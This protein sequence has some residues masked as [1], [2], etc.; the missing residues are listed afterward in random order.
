MLQPTEPLSLESAATQETSFRELAHWAI[1]IVRRQLLVIALIGAL[2]TSLGVFYV[3]I[4]PSTYTAESRIAID[5]RRVQLFPKAT[6]SEGQIDGPAL[7]SETVLAQSEPVVLSVV[8]SLGLAK[9][10]E[11]LKSPGVLGALLG[12]ASHLFSLIKST[13]P[14]SESEATKVA[15]T[16]LSK[17]LL[18]FRV[19]GSYNLSIQYQ[20]ANPERAVQIANAIVEAYI[21]KQLEVKYEPTKRATQ[22]LEG[23]IKELNEKQKLAERLVVDFKKNNNVV[24]AD[25]K[26]MNEQL[27]ADLSSQ[28]SQA[29]Q[30]VSEAK[31]RV[32]RINAVIRDAQMGRVDAGT[33]ADTL[34]KQ[35]GAT[36]SETLNSTVASTLRTRY[37]ELVNREASWSRKYGAK[38]A[39]VVNLR[40]QIHEI[41]GSFLEELKRL[42]DTY[43]NTYEVV[44]SEEQ[45][46]EKRFD[47]AVSRSQPISQ[48]QITL[49]DLESNAKN[50]RT[51][52]DEF[53]QRY[54]DSLQQQSF[55]ISDASITA[56]AALPLEKSGPKTAL[57]LVMAA[58]GGLGFG[59]AVGILRELMDGSFYTK[60]QV[61]SALQTPCIAVVPS[62]KGDNSYNGPTLMGSP[63]PMLSFDRGLD[64]GLNDQRTISRGPD[65]CWAVLNSPFCRFAEGIRSIK[66]AVDL[67]R[68]AVNSKK[69]IGFISSLPHEGKSTIAASLALLMAQASAR[70]ILVDCDLRNPSL[71][72]RLAPNADHGIL[73]VTAGRT[74]LKNA[75]WTDQST[76]L[77]FLPAVTNN[78][79]ICS[80]DILSADATGKLF[81]NLR[82]RYDYVL[83]DLTPLMPI[84]DARATTA[85]VDCY[86]CVIEW[87]RTTTDAVK[88]AFRDAHNISENMLGIV[89]NKADINRLR[90]YY[91]TGESY[92]RNK[93]YGQYG[94][95][96]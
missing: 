68:S 62:L 59:V 19:G 45:D 39:A 3:R 2:G 83:V 8:N 20:S 46:L 55:P 15:V 9:D 44:K 1:G 82:S 10:P 32:D 93:H 4:A 78:P 76:N 6:F 74:T 80:S 51:M 7:D 65:I 77:T 36:L 26:L 73:E 66:L 18:V 69:V 28:I 91:P 67:N 75:L 85:F 53:R 60:E 29:K 70:V 52:Y 50:L 87:G 64:A 34:T 94:F 58:A 90:R 63:K 96:E 17:N 81:E 38:H 72:R 48:A 49:L 30:R 40:E 25:G 79:R 11:F 23:R 35:T 16:V 21:A 22:W 42:G 84:V 24:I 37:L 92:Y 95:T 41:E 86:V 54:A 5:P 56:R 71:S 88:H 89:L 61:E 12:F 57:I 31:A 13:K 27:I 33:V 43:L 14:L 47:D